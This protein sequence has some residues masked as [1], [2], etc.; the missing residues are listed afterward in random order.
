MK[1]I[2]CYGDSNTYGSS[3]DGRPSGRYGPT[4]RYTG[5]I[6]A[7]LGNDWFLIEE[8]LGGRTT[9]TD[10]PVEGVERNG[11]TYLKPCLHSHKPLDIVTI[12]LGTN[13]LKARFNKDS[14]EIARGMQAL[15][16]DTKLY[17][18]DG[19]GTPPE[20]LIISPPAILRETPGIHRLFNATGHDISK[21]LPQEYKRVADQMGVHFL[22]AN[23]HIASSPY[24][25]IH[26]DL[27]AHTS[28]GKAIAE[29]VKAIV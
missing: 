7:E 8:G 2:L 14:A 22:D 27:D 9:V 6:R 24:D 15:I 13:D 23:D 17:G 10:D 1:T 25:G 19:N 29:K 21:E 28:L 18:A 5:V 16:E 3:T 4:E 26:F 20:I 12:M 11:R